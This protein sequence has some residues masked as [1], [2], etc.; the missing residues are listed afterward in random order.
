MPSFSPTAIISSAI[1]L[2]SGAVK[3][4]GTFQ[5]DGPNSDRGG[6]FGRSTVGLAFFAGT[7]LVRGRS[8]MDSD[9]LSAVIGGA[10]SAAFAAEPEGAC[11]VV[12][13]ARPL[14]SRASGGVTARWANFGDPGADLV[15]PVLGNA[16]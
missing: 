5:L 7:G 12:D 15:L 13:L 8:D 4:T 14:S 1:R 6:S 10:S 11:R 16:T 3:P 2:L 9:L